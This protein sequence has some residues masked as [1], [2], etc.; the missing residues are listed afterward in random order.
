MPLVLALTAILACSSTPAAGAPGSQGEPGEPGEPGE[1][2]EAGPTG[3]DGKPGA[4]GATGTP[5]TASRTQLHIYSDVAGEQCHVAPG[6]GTVSLRAE[7]C[8]VGF[9]LMGSESS[10]VLC[11]EDAPARARVAIIL[12]VTAD[13]RWCDEM[14]DEAE[15]CPAGY[16]LVGWARLGGI[17]LED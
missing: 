3:T 1:R 14:E 2:G 4:D 8:P 15:C 10:D 5:G 9:T 17:C 6:D 13:E 7:C 12:D 16:T 11:L